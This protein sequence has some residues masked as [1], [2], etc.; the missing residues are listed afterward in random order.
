MTPLVWRKKRCF[1]TTSMLCD[2]Y[3]GFPKLHRKPTKCFKGS[4]SLPFIGSLRVWNAVSPVLVEIR[5]CKQRAYDARR[6]LFFSVSFLSFIFPSKVS[7]RENLSNC[8]KFAVNRKSIGAFHMSKAIF[9][10]LERF[11]I[12]C[13]KTKWMNDSDA[14]GDLVLIQTSLLLLCKSS[15]SL[16]PTSWHLHTKSREVCIKVRPPPASLAF[17]T[18]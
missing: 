11:P 6:I 13:I 5:F 17:M 3:S 12:E 4:V 16:M 14:G 7:E 2:R 10:L 8:F 9:V 15:C 18:R 1:S